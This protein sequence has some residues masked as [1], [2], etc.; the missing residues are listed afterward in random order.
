MSKIRT[1]SSS[2]V[3]G[4]G[5]ANGV[6]ETMQIQLTQES[7]GSNLFGMALWSSN[8]WG[9]SYFPTIHSVTPVRCCGQ[10]IAL[11]CHS[12]CSYILLPV[13]GPNTVQSAMQMRGRE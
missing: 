4:N 2:T 13:F 3:R 7:E 5:Y 6:W 11:T 8:P 12:I 10:V 9:T 1:D